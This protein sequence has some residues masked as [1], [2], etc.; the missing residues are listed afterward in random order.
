[1]GRCILLTAVIYYN[2]RLGSKVN[3]GK[4]PGVESGGNQV[5]APK[6]F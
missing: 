2:K 3:K 1:M 4:A 5:E 6:V